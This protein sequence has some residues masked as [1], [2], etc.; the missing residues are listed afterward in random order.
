MI[1]IAS[2][3]FALA[4]GTVLISHGI[5]GVLVGRRLADVPSLARI[6]FLILTIVAQPCLVSSA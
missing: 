2:H 4:P 1:Q 3:A 6:A 5:F